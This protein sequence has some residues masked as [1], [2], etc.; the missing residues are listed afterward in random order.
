M[1]ELKRIMYG[2]RWDDSLFS[3]TF[4][5]HWILRIWIKKEIYLKQKYFKRKEAVCGYTESVDLKR[6]AI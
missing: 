6:M 1:I 4:D 5:E 3:C 2:G